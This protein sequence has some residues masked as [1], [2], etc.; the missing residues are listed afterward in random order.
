VQAAVTET[1]SEL[2]ES[3]RLFDVYE[4]EGVGEGRRSLGWA[5]R[6]RADD[7]TLTDEDVE[8]EMNALSA[9]LEKRFDARIRSS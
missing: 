8:A 6:F 4:G 1:A 2:L 7:R 5:F 9:A 3:A